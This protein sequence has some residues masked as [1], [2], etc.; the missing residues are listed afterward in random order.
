MICFNISRVILGRKN[1]KN[2]CFCRE[3]FIKFLICSLQK[4]VF[5][6]EERHFSWRNQPL[7]HTKTKSDYRFW[8]SIAENPPGWEIRI[9][10]QRK[11][12]FGHT[13]NVVSGPGITVTQMPNLTS[14]SDSAPR[15]TPL[16]EKSAF[17]ARKK[18][19]NEQIKNWPCKNRRFSCFSAL[20]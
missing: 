15:K 6:V 3:I 17:W 16:C 19:S 13:P 4:F 20:G 8:F 10:N 1:M 7:Q 9:K 14:D 18:L 2:A 5:F 12:T 11:T